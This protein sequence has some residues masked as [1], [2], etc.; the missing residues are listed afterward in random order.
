MQALCGAFEGEARGS[1]DNSGALLPQPDGVGQHP[2]SRSAA[3]EMDRTRGWKR[4]L[5]ETSARQR[6]LA[7]LPLVRSTDSQPGHHLPEHMD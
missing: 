3:D 1:S 4:M 5:L 6:A 7:L 2:R